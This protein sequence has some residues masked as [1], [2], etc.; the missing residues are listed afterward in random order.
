MDELIALF[1][2]LDIHEKNEIQDDINKIIEQ[3]E[4]IN[5]EEDLEESP[6]EN[7]KYNLEINNIR[8]EI[9]KIINKI[10]HKPRCFINNLFI[11]NFVSL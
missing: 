5:L 4:N 3:I 2:N 6:E 10:K 1:N 11:P 8:L 9:I 7:L